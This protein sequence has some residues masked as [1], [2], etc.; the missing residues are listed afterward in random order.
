MIFRETALEG[1]W[2]IDVERFE[3]DRGFFARTWAPDEFERRG[4][5]S[6]LAQCNLAWNHKKGT[7]RGM[8]FQRAPFEEVKIV[9]CTRGAIF[10]VV[11]DLRPGSPTFGRWISAE[12]SEETRRMLYIPRGMAHGYQTLTDGVEAY[13][14][15]SAPYSPEHAAGVRWDDPRFGIIW[16]MPPTVMS[17]RDKTWPDFV[18]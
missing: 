8:H 16:P 14:H 10:D 4:L 6:T 7:L 5:D 13:Y 3:D 15:V 9:R 1:V 18:P 2:I 11:V 12:L 17:T